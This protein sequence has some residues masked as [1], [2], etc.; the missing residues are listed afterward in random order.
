[1]K[2][3]IG[4]VSLTILI[5]LF[6]GFIHFKSGGIDNLIISFLMYFMLMMIGGLAILVNDI[7]NKMELKSLTKFHQNIFKTLI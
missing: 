3:K 1:M 4:F 2:V 5:F 6:A 7:M